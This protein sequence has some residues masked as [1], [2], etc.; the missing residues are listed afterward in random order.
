MV[1]VRDYGWGKFSLNCDRWCCVMC[2][3]I[4]VGGRFSLNCDRWCCGL[5]QFNQIV[6]IIL[7]NKSKKN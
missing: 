2:P 6:N 4:W 1:G 7:F 5:L 3:R